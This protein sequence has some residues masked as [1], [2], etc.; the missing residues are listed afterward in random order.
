[1]GCMKAVGQAVNEGQA[2]LWDN[3][4][5][6]HLL[7]CIGIAPWGYVYNRRFLEARNRKVTL[8]ISFSLSVC[9]NLT[10][11]TVTQCLPYLIILLC[12]TKKVK[13]I[14]IKY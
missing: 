13:N 14:V 7:R 1:M 11:Y 10:L 8:S 5:M 4:R 6:A 9:L 3:D 12:L 2:F